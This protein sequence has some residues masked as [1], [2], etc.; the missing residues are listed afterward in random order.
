MN[1]DILENVISFQQDGIPVRISNAIDTIRVKVLSVFSLFSV[2]VLHQFRDNDQ[3]WTLRQLQEV[4]LQEVQLQEVQLQ[5][6]ELQRQV[7][8]YHKK[9]H[10]LQQFQEVQQPKDV[11]Q[12]Q[13]LKEIQQYHKEVQ[14]VQQLQEEKLLQ[15]QQ[16]QELKEVQP[17]VQQLQL[18][19]Q[20]L[21]QQHQELQQ[22]GPAIDKGEKGTIVSNSPVSTDG[23]IGIV[24][25]SVALCGLVVFIV[26]ILIYRK[27]K[28]GSIF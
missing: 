28:F 10:A 4:Q 14:E 21:Q 26:G 22:V 27:K 5:V 18:Q 1:G 3:E 13:Q 16:V 2:S 12:D 7:H 24:I 11:Q 8:Q 20:Q 15:L 25:G 17:Q 6:Q 9:I 23:V 19:V